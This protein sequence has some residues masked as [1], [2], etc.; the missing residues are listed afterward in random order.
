M[1]GVKPRAHKVVRKGPMKGVKPRAHKVVS[2]PLVKY[3]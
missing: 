1:K 3:Q 2:P